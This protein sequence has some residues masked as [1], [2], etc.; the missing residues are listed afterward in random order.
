MKRAVL[1]LTLVAG[2]GGCVTTASIVRKYE[3]SLPLLIAAVA[4][5]LVVT[6][7]L[8][9]QVQDYTAGASIGT[10]LA[11]TAADVAV[12]CLLGGCKSLRP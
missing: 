9:S 6:S 10:A 11:V 2:L 4:P 1:A 12:G 8:A 3:V 7:V 5:A